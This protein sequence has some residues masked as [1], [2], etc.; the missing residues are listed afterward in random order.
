MKHTKHPRLKMSIFAHLKLHSIALANSLVVIV[1]LLSVAHGF[2]TYDPTV[3]MS[4]WCL[5]GVTTLLIVTIVVN[6]T[7]LAKQIRMLKHFLNGG[8]QTST[9]PYKN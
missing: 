3:P 7:G 5:M 6:Y 8:K 1:I 4:P 2:E 9:R